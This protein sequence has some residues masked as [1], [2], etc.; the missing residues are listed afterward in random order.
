M[1][2]PFFYIKLLEN[3]ILSKIYYNNQFQRYFR[4]FKEIQIL[5]DI[6]MLEIDK[7]HERLKS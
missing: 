7:F 5:V 2:I 3:E 6:D 4:N 1:A